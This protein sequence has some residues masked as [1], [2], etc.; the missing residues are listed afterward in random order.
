MTSLLLTGLM[1]AATPPAG[2]RVKAARTRLG[3][4][5]TEHARTLGL[6][7]PFKAVMIRAGKKERELELWAG[8]DA[9][10]ALKLV[11]RY[12]VLAASGTL[13][14]KR[15]EGD[16]Q[17][18]EGFYHIALYN[19]LSQFHLS[20]KVSYPNQSDAHFADPARPGGD[21]YI[22]GNALSI[23]CLAMGDPAIEEIYLACL[24]ASQRS[25]APVPVLILPWLTHPEP[26]P[27]PAPTASL[28]QQLTRI[29]TRFTQT[30]KLPSVV[31]SKSG[32]YVLKG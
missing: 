6:H 7:Y 3:S 14:P 31:V 16:S 30:H 32:S 10:G 24:D 18:P 29:N 19:P 28:W 1:L 5:W 20:M 13:G 2:D 26:K 22:H 17:V 9:N 4:F 21:I 8:D 25:H 15:R 11:K 23:G 27:W 12:P